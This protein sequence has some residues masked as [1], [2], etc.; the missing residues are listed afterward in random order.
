VRRAHPLVSVIE[1]Q[2]EKAMDGAAV[3]KAVTGAFGGGVVLCEGGPSLFGQLLASGS[4][5]ELFLTVSP[6][7]AGRKHDQARPGVVDGWTAD[8]DAL[9]PARLVSLHR[10]EDHLFLRY[11]LEP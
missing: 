3:I 10:A 4:A 1:V 8:P 5:Q 6:R 11:S 7:I 9:L 2:R